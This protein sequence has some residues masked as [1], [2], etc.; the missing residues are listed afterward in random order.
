MSVAPSSTR[1]V[2]YAKP[3]VFT[4]LVVALALSMIA[5]GGV[6]FTYLTDCSAFAII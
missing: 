1:K 5:A 6:T 2:A 3:S 4:E